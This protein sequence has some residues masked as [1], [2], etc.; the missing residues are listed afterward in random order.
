MISV[1]EAKETI[2]QHIPVRK[3]KWV[4]LQEAAGRVTASDVIAGTDIPSFPQSSMDGYALKFEDRELP[5]AITGEM[6]AGTS[7]LLTI[8]NGEATRIFTGAPLPEGADTVVMQ[9]KTM[10]EGQYVSVTDHA[11]VP[12]LNVRPKGS[13]VKK[14]EKAMAAGTVL[15][16]AAIGFL[17]GIG[18]STVEVY[19]SPVIGIIMTGNELQEPGKP[20]AF[21]Q[22]YEANSYQL[23]AALRKTG[24]TEV[25]VFT[26]ED[27]PETLADVLQKALDV[28]D[29]VLLN[30]GVS[31]GDYDFVTHAAETCGVQQKFHKI[32]QKP[33]KP[34]FFGTCNEKMVFGLPG[35]PSSSLTCFYEYVLPA[36]EQLTGFPGSVKEIKAEA[37]HD[38]T[39]AQGLT[40]FLKAFYS[41]GKV[42]PLH[43]QESYRLH[44][45]SQANCFIVL[46]EESEG[47]HCGDLVEVH[48]LP[49]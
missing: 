48:L 49:V 46:P 10:V 17:A 9:E 44:S 14:G 12:G 4:P 19:R 31:V 37:S 21:G 45:F 20:L 16:P 8:E 5:L 15:S 2:A 28:S 11:L 13:E 35:N 40:H 7:Q 26:A 29:V 36:L 41:E 24:I 34:L 38:Y 39:K 25:K 43:A 22:V 23:K 42:T 30:G 3:T 6:A 32:R 47:C 1:K 27:D 33:G 18:C